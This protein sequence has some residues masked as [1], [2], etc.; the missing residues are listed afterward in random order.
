MLLE[1]DEDEPGCEGPKAEK[2]NEGC[3]EGSQLCFPLIIPFGGE[4]DDLT[5]EQADWQP[6]DYYHVPSITDTRSC[7]Q[8][9]GVRRRK[10]V[11][12]A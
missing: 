8:F 3:G 12:R 2:R 6:L 7:D 5:D 10:V 4:N 1:P 11:F 9:G